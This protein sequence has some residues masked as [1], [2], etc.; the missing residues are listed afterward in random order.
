MSF[1]KGFFRGA[2]TGIAI[3]FFFYCIVAIWTWDGP[4]G[5]AGGAAAGWLWA[6]KEWWGD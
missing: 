2:M 4:V 5:I 3:I 6:A 1:W